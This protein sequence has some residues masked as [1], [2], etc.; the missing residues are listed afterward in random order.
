MTVTAAQPNHRFNLTLILILILAFGVRIAGAGSYTN[1]A[2]QDDHKDYHTIAANLLNGTGYIQVDGF[3]YGRQPAWSYLLAGAYAIGGVSTRIGAWLLALLGTLTVALTFRAGREIERGM[4]RRAP[5]G[6]IAAL[7]VCL[8]PFLIV[9]DQTL[10]NETLYTTLMTLTLWLMLRRSTLRNSALLGAV[11]GLMALVRSNGIT[12]LLSFVLQNRRWLLIASIVIVLVLLPWTLR[13]AQV[14]G[15]PSPLAPQTGQLLLGTYNQYT[16]SNPDV[17]ALWLYPPELPEGAPY[18]D[19]PYLQREAQWTA[20]ALENIRAHLSEIPR[21]MGQRIARWLLQ[22][23][24]Y[25]RPLLDPRLT[26]A[27]PIFYILLLILSLQGVLMLLL[28]RR[29]RVLWIM[30]TLLLPTAIT[31]ALLFGEA[32]FRA[33]YHPMF[34]LLVGCGIGALVGGRRTQNR[35]G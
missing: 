31:V 12:L 9:Q 8:D 5:I 21:L 30:F 15:I 26:A 23:A 28:Q 20:I 6:L 4:R 17:A 25:P 29:L 35:R 7:V 16:F 11:I 1:A 33:P 19:L 22:P 10:L 14:I 2:L 18:K 34:A 24:W 3:A 32:R 27:Q 13:N